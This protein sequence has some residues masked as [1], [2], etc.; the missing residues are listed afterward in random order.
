M[1]DFLFR[2]K[3]EKT[4]SSARQASQTEQH[5]IGDFSV[6]CIIENYLAA[7]STDCHRRCSA[8]ELIG[9]SVVRRPGCMFPHVRKCLGRGDGT[10]EV[11]EIL[12]LTRG[13]AD[14]REG[15]QD[16]WPCTFS[17]IMACHIFSVVASISCVS[18]T[19]RPRPAR[20]YDFM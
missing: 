6:T 5:P 3:K 2:L 17:H 20:G 12:L 18:S 7:N 10:L 13:T 9:K 8:A 15:K 14:S 16:I 4:R 11:D 19:K 1:I